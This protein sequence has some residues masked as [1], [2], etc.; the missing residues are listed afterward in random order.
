MLQAIQNKAL[1]PIAEEIQAKL[2]K[3]INQL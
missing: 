2:K 1:Q 3:V